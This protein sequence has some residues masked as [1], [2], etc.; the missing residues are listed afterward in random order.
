MWAWKKQ[1]SKEKVYTTQNSFSGPEYSTKSIEETLNN[2]NYNFIKFKDDDELIDQAVNEL[3]SGK[4]IAWFQGKLEFGKR[5]LGNRSILAR[6]DNINISTKIN[7]DIKKRELYQPF[8]ASILSNKIDEFFFRNK[9]FDFSYRYMNVIA[10]ARNEK[11][12]YLNG[13]LH[14]D[15]SSRIHSVHKEDNKLFYNLIKKFENKTTI[16]VLLNT[17]FNLRGE[18]IVDNPIK[19]VSTFLRS[20]C[21][22]LYLDKFKIIND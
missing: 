5:A 4:I 13:V 19:A 6:P 8:A 21:D 7:K 22:I 18:T 1:I 15:K 14:I 16:P 9:K 20:N 11:V 3:D 12:K 2:F 10:E 17:S